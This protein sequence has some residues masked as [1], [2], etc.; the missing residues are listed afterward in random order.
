MAATNAAAAGPN[1]VIVFPPKGII[2][3]GDQSATQWCNAGRAQFDGFAR[4]M[5][6]FAVALAADL[7]ELMRQEGIDGQTSIGPVS[8]GSS[9]RAAGQKATKPLRAIAS[10]AENIAKMFTVADRQMQ[11]Q[12]FEVIK[13]VQ[14]ARERQQ[15]GSGLKI[16]A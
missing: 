12:V 16:G 11:G 4:W 10:E 9:A 14:A 8:W 2:I 6:S 15:R 7:T 13:E 1:P 3:A 5:D